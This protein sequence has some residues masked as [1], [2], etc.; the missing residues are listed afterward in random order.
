MHVFGHADTVR[1]D[2]GCTC[3]G[4]PCLWLKRHTFV[5]V[6]MAARASS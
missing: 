1:P 2:R 6:A 3:H 5:T 4:K